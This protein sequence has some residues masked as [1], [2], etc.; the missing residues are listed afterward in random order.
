MKNK[1]I[2]LSSVCVFSIMCS[3][4]VGIN[5]ANPTQT[6][7]VNGTAR[8]RGISGLSNPPASLPTGSNPNIQD[9]NN[10]PDILVNRT[11]GTIGTRTFPEIKADIRSQNINLQAA[12][13]NS[14]LDL[15]NV[16]SQNLADVYI[17]ESGANIILPTCQNGAMNGKVINFYKWGGVSANPIRLIANPAGNIFNAPNPVGLFTPPQGI[18]YNNTGGT[19]GSGNTLSISLAANNNNNRFTIISLTCMG[20]GPNNKWFLNHNFK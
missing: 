7:D 20:D 19:N 12:S 2:T 18:T 11:D 5:T 15:T 10:F 4:K 8:L 13:P 6:F 1:I 9:S 3:Q 14:N 16:S 17:V